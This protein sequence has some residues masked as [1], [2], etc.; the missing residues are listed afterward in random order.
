MYCDNKT[1]AGRTLSIYK[2]IQPDLIVVT[3]QLIGMENIIIGT[4]MKI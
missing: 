3:M 2:L 1:I 4:T